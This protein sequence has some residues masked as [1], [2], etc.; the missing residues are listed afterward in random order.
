RADYVN[1]MGWERLPLPNGEETSVWYYLL[2]TGWRLLFAMA[3]LGVVVSAIRRWNLGLVLGLAWIGVWLGFALLPQARL[4]NARLLPFMYLSVALLAAIGVGELIR[5]LAQAAAGDARRP[6]PWVTSVLGGLAVLGTLVYV[7]LPINN[8]LPGVIDRTQVAGDDG[9]VQTE[10]SIQIAGRNLF[11]T[12]ALN[13]SAG[14]SANNYS[15]L[16]EK[17]PQPAGC[18]AP[19]SEVA[20]TSGG[21]E[22]F[23]AIVATMQGIGD[24]D[25]YGCGRAMWEYDFDRIGGYGTPMALMMLPY[26][27]DSCI[28][29]QEGLYFESST[30]VPYHF[31]M[32]AELSTQPSQ[33]QRDLPY[34]TFDIDAGVRHMQLLGVDYYLATTANAVD[35]ASRHPDL[36]EIAVSGPWHVYQVADAPLVA[37]LAYEPVVLEGIDESQDGWLPTSSAWFRSAADL[38]RPFAAHGPDDWAR[39]EADP[40]DEPWRLAVSYLR[41]QLG[42]GGPIDQVPE[43]ERTEL[44]PIEVSDITSGDDSISFRVSEPGVPVLVKTSYF[45]NW[46]VSGAEGPYRVT[47]N[48]MV[49]VPTDTEV[50]MHFGRTPLDLLALALTL[51]GVAGV[52]LL[53]RRPPLEMAPTHQTRVGDALDRLVTLSPPSP[54]PEPPVDLFPPGEPVWTSAD[55]GSLDGPEPPG[56]PGPAESPAPPEPPEPSTPPGRSDPAGADPE[57]SSRPGPPDGADDPAQP[58]GDR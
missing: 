45:P 26:F 29:S 27:T 54:P 17:A 46:E 7:A 15:G 21:W 22:E 3:V 36:T 48:L 12:T 25:R 43:A 38:D 14:W 10:S 23:K 28:T 18:D 50:S 44:P 51:L 34:P 57:G 5:V 49:V 52:V 1:D 35:Q 24:D 31:L 20:C 4:W 58:D 55:G 42:E 9:V 33:P 47:P 32:Q 37:P 41:N 40:V 2:P 13:P 30:T 56:A 8:I 53:A 39:A 11:S 19:G 16:E 6:L